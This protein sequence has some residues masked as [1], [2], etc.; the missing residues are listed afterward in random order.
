MNNIREMM[1]EEV[2][3]LLE[4]LRNLEVDSDEYK[5]T[6]KAIT[7]LYQ[8]ISKEKELYLSERKLELD[9]EK[10]DKDYII[11]VRQI[12]LELDKDA[13]NLLNSREQRDLDR[14]IKSK[15]SLLSSENSKK[16]A[17]LNGVKTGVELVGIVAPIVFYGIWMKKGLKFEEEGV[18]TSTTFKGL[19]SKFKPTK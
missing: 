14:D 13:N 11:K 12:E 6:M 10:T 7:T 9:T 15:D 19:M 3:T 16:E 4:K 5:D 2:K 1:E 8:S 18:Y 17:I